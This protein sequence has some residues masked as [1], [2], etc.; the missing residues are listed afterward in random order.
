MKDRNPVQS[1]LITIFAIVLGALLIILFIVPSPI[2]AAAWVPPSGP[3]WTGAL[4][5]N[6]ALLKAELLGKERLRHPEDVAFDGQGRLYTGCEDGNIYRLTLDSNGS[7]T[8]L[9]IF[10]KVGGYPVGLA[11]DKAGQLIVA[12]KGV[13]LVSVDPS[14]TATVLTHEVN[15]TPITYANDLDIASDGRICFSDSSTKFN[16]GWPYD[17]LE[18]KPYGRLLVYDPSTKQTRL[19]RDGLYFANGVALSSDESFLLV[20]ETGRYRIA[21]LYLKGPKSG[22]WD[23][24]AENLPILVDNIDRDGQNNFFVAGNRRL[25]LIDKLQPT[26]FFKDQIAK[27]PFNLLVAIPARK[28]NRYGLVLEMDQNGSIERSL[29][30]PTGRI[31]ATSSAT[32]YDGFLY[33]GTLYGDAV[34]RYPLT[35]P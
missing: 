18:A 7:V 34:G 23:Y 20:G 8:A 1:R 5:T 32:P 12:V 13:G 14:G 28:A 10:A 15:G 16:R 3:S 17:I 4:Q 26:P 33:I 29:Q 25:P 27:L 11:F 21:R 9:V 19:I 30:D 6:N 35:Q 22:T 24:F 2:N 31:Y